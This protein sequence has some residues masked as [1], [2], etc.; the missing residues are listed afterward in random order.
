MDPAALNSS[1]ARFPQGADEQPLATFQP[2]PAVTTLLEETK[3]FQEICLKHFGIL[4]AEI[5]LWKEDTVIAL[6]MTTQSNPSFQR[7][8]PGYRKI[9]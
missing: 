8:T 5:S 9:S 6:L 7:T 4:W 3:Q 2:F 1:P